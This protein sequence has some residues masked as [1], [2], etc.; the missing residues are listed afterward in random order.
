[1]EYE[2]KRFLDALAVNNGIATRGR[3]PIC[4]RAQDRARITARRLGYAYYEAG[5]WHLTDAGRE[6]LASS[7]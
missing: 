6:A 5:A 7:Y 1:M 3:L 4:T 2:L